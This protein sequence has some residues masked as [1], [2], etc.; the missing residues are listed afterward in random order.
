M[1]HHAAATFISQD[2]PNRTNQAEHTAHSRELKLRVMKRHVYAKVKIFIVTIA[3]S[4]P[5]VPIT[6]V[7]QQLLLAADLVVASVKI[8][9]LK[10]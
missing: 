6:A 7:Q 1:G 5:V 2:K 8:Y 10:E 9:K 4:V 3:V